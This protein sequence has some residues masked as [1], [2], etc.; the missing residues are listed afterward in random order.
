MHE[1]LVKS[2]RC[3]ASTTNIVDECE[4]KYCGYNCEL[5]TCIDKMM[6][7][8]ADVIEKLEKD[9]KYVLDCACHLQEE[10][11]ELKKE[12]TQY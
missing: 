9:L 7:D 4:R 2:L 8:A 12:L 11:E 1:E 3:C 6:R 5:P 10:N